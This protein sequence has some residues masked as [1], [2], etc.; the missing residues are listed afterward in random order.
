MSQPA[1]V[2]DSLLEYL[3]RHPELDTLD[4]RGGTLRLLTTGDP[5]AAGSF[6]T[7]FFGKPV[8]FESVGRAALKAVS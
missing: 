5:S 3:R 1:L 7:D 6:A 2:A 8:Q 4:F